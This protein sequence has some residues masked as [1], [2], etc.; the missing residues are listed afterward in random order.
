MVDLGEYDARRFTPQS[1]SDSEFNRICDELRK[2]VKVLLEEMVNE[3]KKEA[4]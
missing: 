1:D 4:V 3:E 2:R